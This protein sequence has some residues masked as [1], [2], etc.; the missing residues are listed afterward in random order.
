M[1]AQLSTPA[2]AVAVASCALYGLAAVVAFAIVEPETRRSTAAFAVALGL[3]ALRQ[4]V[5]FTAIETES[6]GLATL[7]IAALSPVAA[8]LLL[9]C[10]L[11]YRHDRVRR[12]RRLGPM[13]DTALRELRR[14]C[15][16]A[17]AEGHNVGRTAG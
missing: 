10:V 8:A 1:I 12:R 11:F 4:V 9:A 6:E 2:I 13:V 7:S 3:L 14:R 17:N 15:D 16:S 5:G